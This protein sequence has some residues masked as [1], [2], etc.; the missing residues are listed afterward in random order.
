MT[1]VRV[2]VKK[3]DTTFSIKA[4]NYTAKGTKKARDALYSTTIGGQ[5]LQ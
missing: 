5:I 1:Q 2:L 3:G 4:C